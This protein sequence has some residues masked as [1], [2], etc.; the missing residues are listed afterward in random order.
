MAAQITRRIALPTEAPVPHREGLLLRASARSAKGGFGTED[1]VTPK[2]GRSS[3]VERAISTNHDP[4][5]KGCR[6]RLQAFAAH[7][8][9]HQTAEERRTRRHHGAGKGG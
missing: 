8:V 5:E 2:V 1:L 6:K 9:K 4:E 7:K 3:Y